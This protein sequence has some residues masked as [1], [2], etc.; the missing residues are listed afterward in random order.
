MHE[1]EIKRDARVVTPDGDFGHVS[2]VIVDSTTNEL[3]DIVVK[4]REDE[5]LIPSSAIAAVEGETVRLASGSQATGQFTRF[6]ESEFMTVDDDEIDR[7]SSAQTPGRMGVVDAERDKVKLADGAESN[8]GERSMP[9]TDRSHRMG[10]RPV[11]DQMELRE[12]ELTARKERADAGRVEIEKDVVSEQRT[13]DVPVAREEVIVHRNPVD[14]TPTDASIDA[15]EEI[16]VSVM[17]EEVIPEKRTVV[18]EE[19]EVEKR[20]FQDTERVSDEVHRE[21]ARTKSE[22]DVNVAGDDV[23]RGHSQTWDEVS[24]SYRMRWQRDHGTSGRRWEDMEPG[25]R[26]GHEMSNDPRYR[27]REWS[28]VEPDMQRDYQSW[29][30]QHGYVSDRSAWDQ[31][32]DSVRSTWTESRA[33]SS[34]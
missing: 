13:I 24:D 14:R 31:I 27:N 21:V 17:R 16:E 34:R 33:R 32:K 6:N 20:V 18:Y 22:G 10:R 1:H 30:R 11:G 26:F 7:R 28:E 15:S 19:I 29:S 12:E 2:R 8:A 4:N 3:T 5:W 23:T 9:L 25:Y